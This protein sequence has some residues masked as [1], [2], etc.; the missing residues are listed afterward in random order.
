MIATCMHAMMT[1]Q[2]KLEQTKQSRENK[3]RDNIHEKK[4]SR[5]C[6]HLQQFKNGWL[7]VKSRIP[8]HFKSSQNVSQLFC[9]ILLEHDLIINHFAVGGTF[10]E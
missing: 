2:A 9:G 3:W 4:F 5:S 10:P 6:S 8:R 7:E 1:K